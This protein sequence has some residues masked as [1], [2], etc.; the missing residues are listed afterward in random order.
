MSYKYFYNYIGKFQKKH[1]V[2]AI[3]LLITFL[4]FITR[5][6]L[7]AKSEE[8]NND[9]NLLTDNKTLVSEESTISDVYVDV[10][11]E[12]K[13]PGVYKL[14]SSNRVI[15]A[16]KKGEGL[17]ENADT[18]CINLSKLL[19]DE[20]VIIIPSKNEVKEVECKKID[21]CIKNGETPSKGKDSEDDN[22]ISINNATLDELMTIPKIGESKAK[23]IIEYREKNNGFK[24]LEELLNISGIGQKTLDEIKEYITL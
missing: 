22:K 20:M 4:F 19:T 18:S 23:T 10:K 2:I 14:N 24:S 9:I 21:E 3:I 16:I 8:I 6:N 12:V 1:I 7:N 11:G 5:I 13:V 17:T 15:D